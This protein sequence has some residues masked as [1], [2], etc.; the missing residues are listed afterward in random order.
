MQCNVYTKVLSTHYRYAIR[1][2][3][4]KAAHLARSAYPAAPWSLRT[5]SLDE[6]VRLQVEVEARGAQQ[7]SLHVVRAE[8]EVA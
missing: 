6:E 8:P 2:Y 5:P 3:K 7:H 4:S 1:L